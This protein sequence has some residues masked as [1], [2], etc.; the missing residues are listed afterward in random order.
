[1]RA[2]RK[3]LFLLAALL[4]CA[5]LSAVPVFAVGS[6]VQQ[7]ICYACGSL[8]YGSNISGAGSHLLVVVAADLSASSYD[9]T[10]K[11][12]KGN[13]WIP[14]ASQSY[15]TGQ[16]CTGGC[17][18]AIFFATVVSTGADTVTVTFSMAASGMIAIY[19]VSG[20]GLVLAG[21]ATGHWSCNYLAPTCIVGTSSSNSFGSYGFLVGGTIG[22]CN[23]QA[24]GESGYGISDDGQFGSSINSTSGVASP[25]HYGISMT[26]T[27]IQTGGGPIV[28]ADFTLGGSAPTQS[29][30]TLTT[31]STSTTT[32]TVSTSCTST[33]TTTTTITM[34]STLTTTI[35]ANGTLQFTVT[36]N[37]PGLA[38]SIEVDGVIYN[39]PQT[40]FWSVGS[41]HSIAALT[42][43]NLAHSPYT[44]FTFV[45]WSDGGLIAHVITAPTS[46]TTYTALFATTATS[47][48]CGSPN[49][50]QQLEKACVVPALLGAWS[51]SIGLQ[52]WLGFV[53]L[54]TNVAVYNKT[55]SV[56]MALIIL[57]VTGATFFFFLPSYVSL[58]AQV[59]LYLGIA[60]IVVKGI[61][62]VF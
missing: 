22:G 7:G 50:L 51:A 18:A 45:S 61:L 17:N 36:S 30:T 33:V 58:I 14:A 12:S 38:S 28:G 41:T 16:Y 60:G 23:T 34:T 39:S 8:A 47:V 55:Q 59:F 27:G 19:E 2:E 31:T 11:D 54:G 10:I 56:L 26:C 42:P 3:A 25:T 13:N 15:S 53:L 44:S 24:P 62:R 32:T 35:T 9:I 40:F 46:S 20:T 37:P 49:P 1:M 57:W 29:T 6:I 4:G 21:S 5:A 52:P 48:S 43:C